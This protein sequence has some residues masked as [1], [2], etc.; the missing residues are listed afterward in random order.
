MEGQADEVEITWT[1]LGGPEI[2]VPDR[3]G[4]GSSVTTDLVAATVNGAVTVDYP[5]QGL[6]W[7][8]TM[9]K[10]GLV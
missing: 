9:P 1:E 5:P 8:L 4:F 7:R 6:I 10:S 2:E 3:A